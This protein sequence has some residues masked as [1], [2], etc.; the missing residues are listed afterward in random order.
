MS[1]KPLTETTDDEDL[2]AVEEPIVE[3]KPVVED[4]GAGDED[5]DDDA[6]GD[7]DHGDDDDEGDSRTGHN[8]DDDEDAAVG[9]KAK[10][11]R[12]RRLQRREQQRIARERAEYELQMLR[13]QNEALE[14]R[15]R[16][17]EAG[18]IDTHVQTIEQRLQQAQA[19][20]RQAERI[21]ERAIE[22]GNGADVTAAMRIRD[23][24]VAEANNL[25]NARQ[26]ALQARQQATAPRGPDPRVASNAK[27]WADANPWFNNN[28]TDPDSVLAK[29]I[30]NQLAAEGRN[31]ADIG[32]WQELS[33]RL[34]ERAPPA[35]KSPRKAEPSRGKEPPPMG[36]K[37]EHVP[38]TTR[39]EIYVTPERKQAMIDA[40][41]W[42]NPERRAKTLKAYQAYDQRS[43]S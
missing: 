30:D 9:K 39:K 34:R 12:D 31:P 36:G 27:A 40:G 17:V 13:G 6:K 26:Q 29:A 37:R 16:A 42:D 4:E 19:D 23:E 38:V 22:A 41:I 24:A 11:N 21:I 2:I 10:T 3:K 15:L 1:D 33:R 25:A 8:T 43:A 32:Y 14:Q 18:T 7:D 28:G 5:D 35:E 20:A